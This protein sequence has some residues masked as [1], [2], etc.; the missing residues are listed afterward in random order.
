MWGCCSLTWRVFDAAWAV[1]ARQVA[2]QGSAQLRRV[3][4]V[5]G[6]FLALSAACSPWSVH[7]GHEAGVRLQMAYAVGMQA[8][9]Q[10]QVTLANVNDVTAFKGWELTPWRGWT[11]LLDLGYYAHRVFAQMRTAGVHFVTR[12]HPQ[13][14]YRVVRARTL[15]GER[16]PEGDVVV[17][18]A[19]IVLGSAHNHNGAVLPE[20]RLVVSRTA[21]WK[22]RLHHRP[23]RP[24][25]RRRSAAL[26]QALADR[27]VLSLAEACIG[28]NP[29]LRPQPRR[30]PPHV[31]D[32]QHRG[33][34]RTTFGRTP[35]TQHHTRLLVA[36][37]C[38]LLAARTPPQRSMRQHWGSSLASALANVENAFPPSRER[39]TIARGLVSKAA[40]QMWQGTLQKRLYPACQKAVGARHAVPLPLS[41]QRRE[42]AQ[43]RLAVI[44]AGAQRRRPSRWRLVPLQAVPCL[45]APCPGP[46]VSWRYMSTVLAAMRS[47]LNSRSTRC[48]PCAPSWRR[49]A[50]SR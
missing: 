28:G 8:P 18:D 3:V 31:S 41:Q 47:W 4:A 22:T 7:K 35:P 36:G 50:G 29:P 27:V 9:R 33:R 48:R 13:A 10:L 37:P 44:F 34:A 17:Q 46:Y 21:K 16:T 32:R 38:R 11:V 42:C 40:A 6:S 39:Q 14:A 45:S 43:Q 19:V 20:M 23:P 24:E 12:L 26:P 30:R 1:V 25:R 2:A 15:T 49:S 5:D